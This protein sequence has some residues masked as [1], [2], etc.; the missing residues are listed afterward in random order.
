MTADLKGGGWPGASG[1]SIDHGVLEFF[2]DADGGGKN[3]IV[4]NGLIAWIN[5]V[6]DGAAENIWKEQAD[7]HYDVSEVT[8]A[9]DILWQACGDN[10]GEKDR[11]QGNN[12]KRSD[13]EDIHKALKRLK[14]DHKL[15]LIL[16]TSGMF[17]KAPSFGGI[18]EQSSNGD[19]ISKV[20]DLEN[21]IETFMKKQNDQMKELT[22]IITVSATQVKLPSA[23]VNTFKESESQETPRTK[24]R[25]L[26]EAELVP[27]APPADIMVDDGNVKSAAKTYAAVTGSVVGYGHGGQ[28]GPAQ[29]SGV[30]GITPLGPRG[31][32]HSVLIFGKATSSIDKK[33]ESLAADVE[34]VATGVSR[35]ASEEQFKEFMTGKGIEVLEIVKLTTYEHARTITFKITIKASQYA[36]AMDPDI[37]PLRVGVRHYRQPKRDNNRGASWA[38]Q[39]AQSGGVIGQQQSQRSYR[40]HLNPPSLPQQSHGAHQYY[41]QPPGYYPQQY[42]PPPHQVAQ[43]QHHRPEQPAY[44]VPSVQGIP[45][46]NRFVMEG[47]PTNVCN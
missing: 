26:I 18:S 46:Q 35:D 14:S 24:K 43:P 38:E 34:L 8:E 5:V 15:P 10:I 2:G 39:S 7:S 40:P 13:L 16:G 20:K 45:V 44:Q 9:K 30:R 23:A 29:A 32:K 42:L 25:K 47:F 12:K 41:Q 37:W 19:V 21:V 31:R 1:G 6:H 11:R 22:E 4:I 33:D 3:G 17:A 36:K 28:P 27:S